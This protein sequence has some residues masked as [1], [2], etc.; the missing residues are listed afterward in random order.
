MTKLKTLFSRN[1]C[2]GPVLLLSL[3]LILLGTLFSVL[4]ATALGAVFMIIGAASQGLC[5]WLGRS[6]CT[7]FRR[8][9]GPGR[10]A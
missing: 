3:T 10:T 6:R 9:L 1:C 4:A 2:G 5:L 8:V 7:N